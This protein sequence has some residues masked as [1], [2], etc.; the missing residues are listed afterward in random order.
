LEVGPAAAAASFRRPP[1]AV[2]PPLERRGDRI[3]LLRESADPSAML[4]A[5]EALLRSLQKAA[6]TGLTP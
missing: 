5:A 4:T 6:R 2:P 3:L 1:K